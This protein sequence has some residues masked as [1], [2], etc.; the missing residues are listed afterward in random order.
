MSATT[1][2][3]NGIAFPPIALDS[4]VLCLSEAELS[5]ALAK[6]QCQPKQSARRDGK[7]LVANCPSCKE[8][9]V[10]SWRR[11]AGGVTLACANECTVA[12]IAS[13]LKLPP[14]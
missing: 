1:P 8:P 2:A 4:E 10:L 9:A 5:D 12:A 6:A 14:P 7:Q 13:A 3:V 11:V